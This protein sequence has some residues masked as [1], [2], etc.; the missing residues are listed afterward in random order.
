L[1]EVHG[2]KGRKGAS[3]G[4]IVK[5]SGLDGAGGVTRSV[6]WRVVIGSDKP[7]KIR[8]RIFNLGNLLVV[9]EVCKG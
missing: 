3:I 1:R 2:G 7:S 8:S 6:R 5:D 9:L 4:L